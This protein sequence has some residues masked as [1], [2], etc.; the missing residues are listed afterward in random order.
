MKENFCDYETSKILKELGFDYECIACYDKNNMLATY[1]E[2]F[3]PKNYNK[4]AYC[5]SAPLWQ[6]TKQWLWEKHKMAIYPEILSGYYYKIFKRG[7][8][9]IGGL[10]K[11]D[12]SIE[13]ETEGIKSAVKYLWENKQK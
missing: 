11:Y 4:D 1:T 3:K 2:L 7:E 8:I 6:Q 13:A 9:P 12:S 10:T 5:I